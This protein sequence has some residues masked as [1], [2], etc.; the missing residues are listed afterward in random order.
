MFAHGESVTRLRAPAGDGI[1][2]D[3]DWSAAVSTP[4]GGWAVDDTAS[5]ASVE[6]GREPVVSDFVLYRQEPADVASTDRLVVR[7][8]TCEVQGNPSELVNPFTGWRPGQVVRAKI[9]EG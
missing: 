6:P 4:L 3:F 8:K 9:V 5:T 2:D 1:H 7:G